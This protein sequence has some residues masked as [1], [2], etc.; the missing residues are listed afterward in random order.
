MNQCVYSLSS[1]NNEEEKKKTR[2]KTS[3][4]VT[5][6]FKNQGFILNLRRLLI[7]YSI[8]YRSFI[9]KN[10]QEENFVDILMK[11]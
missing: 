7:N 8:Y 11:N 1:I 9:D 5:N 3:M 4:N 6:R 2:K 10:K